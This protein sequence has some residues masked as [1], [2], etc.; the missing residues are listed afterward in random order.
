MQT[1]LPGTVIPVDRCKEGDA[2]RILDGLFA[3]GGLM[4]SQIVSICGMEAHCVQNWVKRGFCPPPTG[5][6][7]DRAQLCR[8]LTIQ[9]LKDCLSLPD[10]VRLLSYVNGDLA[11]RED[12]IIPDDTLY[13]MLVE[14]ICRTDT[15]E[16]IQPEEAAREI[17]GHFDSPIPDAAERIRKVLVI[18]TCAYRASLLRREAEDMMTTIS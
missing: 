7:Y 11:A 15:P 5:K 13:L 14:M 4:L 1:F 12:D 8:L 2:S 18:M 17:V 16:G 6:R 9:M 3:G 10:I